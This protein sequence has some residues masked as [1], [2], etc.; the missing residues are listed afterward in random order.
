MRPFKSVILVSGGITVQKRSL[1][2]GAY[3]V[4]NTVEPLQHEICMA[5]YSLCFQEFVLS[6]AFSIQNAVRRDNFVL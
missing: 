4:S 6:G 2:T 3:S 1:V 5:K